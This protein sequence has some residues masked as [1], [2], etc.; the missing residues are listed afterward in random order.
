VLPRRNAADLD[1]VLKELKKDMK[2]VLVDKVPD[3]LK[4]A[5]LS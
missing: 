1:E 2:I 5:L 4:R 3:V